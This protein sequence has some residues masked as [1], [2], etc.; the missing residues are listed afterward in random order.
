MECI[1]YLREKKLLWEKSKSID[2]QR[3]QDVLQ[4][5]IEAPLLTAVNHG[6]KGPLTPTCED[7]RTKIASID[8]SLPWVSIQPSVHQLSA[9]ETRFTL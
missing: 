3:N 4:K 2:Q 5:A 6:R 8:R 7:L 9:A 1:Q